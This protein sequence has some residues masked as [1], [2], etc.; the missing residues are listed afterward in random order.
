MKKENISIESAKD[1]FNYM[2][3]KI[4]NLKDKIEKEMESINKIFDKTM[5]DIKDFFQKKYEELLKEEKE[6]QEK[7]QNEVTKTKEKMENFLSEINEEIRLNNRIN[8]MITK[9]EKEDMNT[10][11]IISFVSKIKESVKSMNK[12]IEKPINNIK[13]NFEQEK[14]NLNFEEYTI[15]QIQIKNVDSIIL[16]ESNRKEEF[17]RLLFEWTGCQNMELLYRGTRDGMTS[18]IFHNKCDNQGKTITLF[19]ND[20]GHIFGGYAS[21]PWSTKALGSVSAPDSFIFTLTNIYNL[22]LL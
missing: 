8:K 18:K 4:T 2:V 20:K 12:T 13:F 14:K 10:V 7:L 16:N 22:L 21:I 19:R 11:K 6:L 9:L 1:E 3:D 5:N 17:T 15:N